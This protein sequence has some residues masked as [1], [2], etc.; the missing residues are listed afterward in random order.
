MKKGQEWSKEQ[1][2]YL[3]LHYASERA[4]D[5]GAKIGKTRSSVQHKANRLKLGKDPVAFFDIRSRAM[6]GEN[7]GNFKGYRRR[8]TKGYIACYKPDH[9][10]ASAGGLVMEHRLVMEEILGCFLPKSIDVH[11]L[12]GVK[13]DNRIENLAIMTHGAHTALHNRRGQGHE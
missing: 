2:E 10:Y 8:T 13:D 1:L 11:H 7:S 9:P 12:N 5:I 3:R 4:E 6:S